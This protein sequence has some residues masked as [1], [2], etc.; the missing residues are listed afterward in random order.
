VGGIILGIAL[1][2]YI[3]FL[4][5]SSVRSYVLALTPTSTPTATMTVTPTH[6]LMPTTTP[7]L[8]PTATNTP[9]PTALPSLTPTPL[10]GT[11]ARLVWARSGCYDAYDAIGRIPEG[12]NVRFL[13]SERRFD[14]FSRECVLVEYDNNQSSVIGWILLEDLVQ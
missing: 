2:G 4:V 10:V 1:V 9:L 14:G 7:T 8:V 11:V 13:P 3:V 12:A 5:F 6:T